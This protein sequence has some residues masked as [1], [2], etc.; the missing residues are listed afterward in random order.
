MLQSR[1]RNL[2]SF[3]RIAFLASILAACDSAVAPDVSNVSDTMTCRT[4]ITGECISTPSFEERLSFASTDELQTYLEP[5][6]DASKETLVAAEERNGFETLRA[7]LD[8]N[9]DTEETA[10]AG[11]GSDGPTGNEARALENDGVTREDFPVGDAFLSVLNHRGEVQIGGSVYKVT[12]DYV[13]EVSARDVAVLNEKVPTLS[14]PAPTDG[15]PR[16]RINKVETTLPR[17]SGEQVATSLGATGPRFHHLPGVGGNCYVYA[18]DKRMH[19]KSY[20]SNFF[21]YAE[22]GVTTEWERKKKFLWWTTW[23]NTWQSGTLKHEFQ[24]AVTFGSWSGPWFPIGPSGGVQTQTGTS[25]IHRTVAWGVG[26]GVRLRGNI[27]TRHDV[28]NSFVTGSCQTQA[29]A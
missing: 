28:S 1:G 21:F 19:G 2:A 15:D 23:S 7:Y 13:Y 16:I 11:E 29:G 8:P 6:Q 22:A 9:E 18:G 4:Y 27:H 5:L 24:S 25:G 12:R 26:F 3:S 20:I 10:R 17:E 14:S